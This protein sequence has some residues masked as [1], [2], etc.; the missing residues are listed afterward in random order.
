MVKT[1]GINVA[2]AE[3]EEVLSGH[4][5]VEL[6]FVTA[7]P[8]ERLDEALAAVIVLKTGASATIEDLTN[9]CRTRLAAYK[10]P[11][12]LRFVAATQLPLTTTGKL[13]RNR[14]PGLFAEDDA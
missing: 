11:R 10:T 6:A 12:H 4:P 2:P 9:H 5:A 7:V 13:Q 3:V 8:D 1:G 14:L